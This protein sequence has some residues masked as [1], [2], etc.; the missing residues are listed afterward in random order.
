VTWQRGAISGIGAKS[1]AASNKLAA[2]HGSSIAAALAE[3]AAALHL[4]ASARQRRRQQ[5]RSGSALVAQLLGA[6][7]ICAVSCAAASI[8]CNGVVSLHRGNQ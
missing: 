5:H 1:A 2:R 4:A 7:K 3:N 8:G 6:G